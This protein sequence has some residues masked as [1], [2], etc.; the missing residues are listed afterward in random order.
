MGSQSLE[1]VRRK[2]KHELIRKALEFA[3]YRRDHVDGRSLRS[4]P[5]EART[6]RRTLRG[7]QAKSWE[8]GEPTCYFNFMAAK[9]TKRSKSSDPLT[10]SVLN[11]PAA[12]KKEL[13]AR[14][15]E[16]LSAPGFDAQVE[17]AWIRECEKRSKSW[18]PSKAIDM[19]TMKTQLR[20]SWQKVRKSA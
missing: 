15:I 6:L 17:D 20:Q 16:D 13:V 14:I 8:I 9:K 3:L 12:W 19:K 4:R 18:D 10:E 5:R 7:G 1:F 11:M 2:L